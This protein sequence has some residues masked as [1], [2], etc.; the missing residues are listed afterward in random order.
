VKSEAAQLVKRGVVGKVELLHEI[1]WDLPLAAAAAAAAS[2]APLPRMLE[3]GNEAS[4]V[5]QSIIR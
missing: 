3:G 4:R 1:Q 5:L 2:S